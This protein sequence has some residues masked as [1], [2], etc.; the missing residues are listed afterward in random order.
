M[1]RFFFRIVL[2]ACLVGPFVFGWAALQPDP[3]LPT[4]ATMNPKMAVQARGFAKR[5]RDAMEAP[6][7]QDGLVHISA[8]QAELNSGIAAAS[9]LVRPLRGMS[10]VDENGVRV[11]VSGQ[12]PKLADLGWVNFT[13]QVA[14]SA[15]GLE[16]TEIKLGRMTLPP[17]LTVAAL[18]GVLNLAG[19]G[20]VGSVLLGS[21]ESLSTESGKVVLALDG[22]VAG[23]PPMFD[24]IKDGFRQIAGMSSTDA[25]SAHYDAMSDA[26]RQGQLPASGSSLP[27]IRFTLARV[28]E[29]EHETIADMRSDLDAAFLALGAHC[30]DRRALEAV[31][32]ELSSPQVQSPCAG[33]QLLGRNDLR[34]HFTLSAALAAAGGA[35]ASFGMGE[36]KELLDAGKSGGSGYSFDD[37]AMDRAGIAL[38]ERASGGSPDALAALVAKIKREGDVAPAISGLASQMSEAEFEARF[39]G[40]DTPAYQAQIAEIDARIDALAVHLP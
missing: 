1:F 22:G 27:W 29:A 34:Q 13:A 40:V 32:G 5:V 4:S 14:P 12:I 17:G 33:T 30:G 19:P 9:R 26:G 31:V 15:E 37:I 10:V 24:K 23:G 21:I 8:S 28:A 3:I 6:P 36:V 2:L 39:G 18:R 16:I 11:L 25:V 35:G 7:T 38:I 20:E